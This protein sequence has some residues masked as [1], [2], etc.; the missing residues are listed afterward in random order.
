MKTFKELIAEVAAIQPAGEKKFVAKHKVAVK[1]HPAANENQFTAP[2]GKDKSKLAG[3]HDA[4][5]I[6]NYE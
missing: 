5:D 6:K 3:Y 2:T 1:R 4:E